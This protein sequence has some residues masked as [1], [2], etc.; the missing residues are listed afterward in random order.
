MRISQNFFIIL[1]HFLVVVHNNCWVLFFKKEL[2]YTQIIL[3]NI[4]EYIN[5]SDL[6][7]I[8]M[9]NL[10]QIREAH[11]L[12]QQ[13]FADLFNLSQQSVYKYE[14]NISE[15]SLQTLIEI[16]DYF[17]TSVDYL[18]GHTDNPRPPE[19]RFEETL[20]GEEKVLVQQ[21][22]QLST[23]YKS[24]VSMLVDTHLKELKN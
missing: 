6:E 20:T 5:Y 8:D 19:T 21:Y 14:N 23:C 24:L 22:R 3:N 7:G 13:K 12:S 1:S 9:K 18:I 2:C 4:L 11:G 17:N 15:P 16:S 10:K